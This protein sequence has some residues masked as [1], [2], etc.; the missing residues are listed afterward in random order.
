M[1]FIHFK[2]MEKLFILLLKIYL[3]LKII[4]ISKNFISDISQTLPI[5]LMNNNKKLKNKIN[6]INKNNKFPLKN[7][8]KILIK[9]ISDFYKWKS[10]L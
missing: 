5:F 6:R 9:K 1:N 10:L 2:L 4:K 7:S 3:F 8:L